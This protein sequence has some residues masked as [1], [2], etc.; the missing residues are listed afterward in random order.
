MVAPA[1]NAQGRGLR[2]AAAL[3]QGL[4]FLQFA[5]WWVHH[6]PGL[7]GRVLAHLPHD[8]ILT[9]NSA[10]AIPLGIAGGLAL[11]ALIPLA[12]GRLTTLRPVLLV[13]LAGL[14]ATAANFW[15]YDNPLGEG[16]ILFHVAAHHGLVLSDIPSLLV[17]ALAIVVLVIGVVGICRRSL[18]S[19]R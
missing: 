14:L 7:H 1:E 13:G 15:S 19:P 11:L 6:G 9:R 12:L 18:D 4:A 16:P 2:L 10:T 3:V 5:H 17:A 8:N